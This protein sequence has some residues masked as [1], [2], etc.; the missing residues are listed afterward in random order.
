[1][2]YSYRWFYK[3]EGPWQPWV[4][5]IYGHHFSN[6]TCWLHVSVSHFGH[7]HHSSTFFSIIT[8]VVLICD[9]CF[10]CL[11]VC[12]FLFFLGPH[13]RHMEVPRL[14]VESEL[15]LPS[16]A[17]ATAP[18]DPSCICDLHQSSQQ[19]QILNPLRIKG[20]GIKPAPSWILVG[21]FTAERTWTVIF[22]FTI[23]KDYN[24]LKTHTMVS[25]L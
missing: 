23:A 25:I 8:F 15:Q 20:P 18:C 12:F 2:L 22:D 13:P 11:F 6:S 4:K 7:S 17:T 10:F 14:G 5:Q 16:Y 19:C 9:Q 3:L 1:M 24:S 21:F